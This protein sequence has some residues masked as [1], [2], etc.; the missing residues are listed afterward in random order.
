MIFTEREMKVI[1]QIEKNGQKIGTREERIGGFKKM[2]RDQLSSSKSGIQQA[3]YHRL[4]LDNEDIFDSEEQ[5]VK[6]KIL[7]DNLEIIDDLLR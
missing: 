1:A 2:S 5:Q 6:T 3:L 7:Q 4:S